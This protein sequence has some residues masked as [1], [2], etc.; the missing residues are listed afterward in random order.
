MSEKLLCIDIPGV[1]VQREPAGAGW[2][3]HVE[4]KP[5]HW[6]RGDSQDEAIGSLIRRLAVEH[7]GANWR[8]EQ[9]A[10]A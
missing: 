10:A 6:S 9:K 8:R 7:Q 5:G 3:A 2:Q 1:V 4:G